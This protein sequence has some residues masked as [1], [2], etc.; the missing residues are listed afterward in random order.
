MVRLVNRNFKPVDLSG[1]GA[2]YVEG[3][4]EISLFRS[5]IAVLQAWCIYQR[6]KRAL[7]HNFLAQFSLAMADNEGPASQDLQA[8]DILV[9][10]AIY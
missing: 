3:S 1:I 6:G 8:F 10:P 7:F 5:I 9:H 4:Q 2:R